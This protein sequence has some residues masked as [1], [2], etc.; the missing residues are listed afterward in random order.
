MLYFIT[1]TLIFNR[2]WTKVINTK[3]CV[4]W[5]EGAQHIYQL[6]DYNLHF[7]YL[8]LKLVVGKV[9]WIYKESFHEKLE[10]WWKQP[11]IIQF[12][13]QKPIYNYSLAAKSVDR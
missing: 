11:M 9:V 1:G 2:P 4:H 5:R 13:A 10:K 8:I 3:Y 7:I 12:T 6:V